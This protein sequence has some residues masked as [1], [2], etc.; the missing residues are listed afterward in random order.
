[1]SLEILK[2]IYVTK[3]MLK[4]S[5]KGNYAISESI[6]RRITNKTMKEKYNESKN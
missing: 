5:I 6:I 2:V 4:D 1:M 3:N